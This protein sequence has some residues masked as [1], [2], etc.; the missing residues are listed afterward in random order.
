MYY[1]IGCHALE[2]V[3]CLFMLSSNIWMMIKVSI[4]MSME[5]MLMIFMLS[6]SMLSMSQYMHTGPV[7]TYAM[8]LQD[9][10]N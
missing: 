10:N 5:T 6:M 3:D 1:Y 9:Q 7:D 4:T 2:V 8:R